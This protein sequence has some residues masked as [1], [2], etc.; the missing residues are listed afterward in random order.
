MAIGVPLHGGGPWHVAL[1]LLLY[2]KACTRRE[3]RIYACISG[4]RTS[5]M[6]EVAMVGENKGS[7]ERDRTE[8]N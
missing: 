5:S 7:T 2:C 6:C 1:L 3:V 8:K 4:G